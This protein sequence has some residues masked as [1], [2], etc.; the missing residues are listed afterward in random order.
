M[1]HWSDLN[2]DERE[3]R[4]KILSENAKRWHAMSSEERL[5]YR[6]EKLAHYNSR[7]AKSDR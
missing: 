7:A 5:I 2:E 1:K 3:E 4:R 6:A